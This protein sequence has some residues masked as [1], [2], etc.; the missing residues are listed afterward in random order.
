MDFPSNVRTSHAALTTQQCAPP[1]SPSAPPLEH[2]E[3]PQ[4][5]EMIGL[6]LP[7]AKASPNVVRAMSARCLMKYLSQRQCVFLNPDMHSFLNSKLGAQH[8]AGKL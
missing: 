7:P 6:L 2:F 4:A 1:H 3:A 8:A 5:L